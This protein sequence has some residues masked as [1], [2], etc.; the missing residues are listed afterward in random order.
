MDATELNGGRGAAPFHSLGTLVASTASHPGQLRTPDND[1]DD[2]VD[3]SYVYIST[4]P[5]SSST[6]TSRAPSPALQPLPPDRPVP[7]PRRPQSISQTPDHFAQRLEAQVQHPD[8]RPPPA[9]RLTHSPNPNLFDSKWAR[10][11][12]P[13]LPLVSLEQWREGLRH[14]ARTASHPRTYIHFVRSLH[15]SLVALFLVSVSAT[16]SNKTLLR[17]FFEGLTYSLTTWQLAC[18]TLGTMLAERIGVYRP[19]RVPTKHIRLVQAVA[20]VFSCEILCSN[21]AL[22]LVPVPV[23]ASRSRTEMARH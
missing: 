2:D 22:R 17:G 1:D 15:P 6:A 14:Y 19:Q 4:A 16:L 3:H 11:P 9:P 23:S 7:K 13:A 21:L 20:F 18:A 12:E 5:S 8:A 10:Q